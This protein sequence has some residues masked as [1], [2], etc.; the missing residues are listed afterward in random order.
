MNETLYMLLLVF[1]MAAVTY[2]IRV[3]PFVIF[4]KKINSKF[5]KSFLYYIPYAVL[6]AMTFPTVFTVTGNV[7]TS[8]AGTIVAVIASLN[9]KCMMVTV[10][11][12]AVVAVLIAQGILLI[13]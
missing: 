3:T 9:K 13:I 11:I 12:L 1:V 8:T 7:I 4:K 10:A 2:L 6:I 5:I